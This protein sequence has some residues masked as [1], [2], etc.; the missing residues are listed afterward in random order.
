[1]Q[2]SRDTMN[3]ICAFTTLNFDALEDTTQT[4]IELQLRVM[5]NNLP[6]ITHIEGVKN[7]AGAKYRL[8]QA[9]VET[10]DKLG[11]PIDELSKTERAVDAFLALNLPSK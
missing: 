8:E 5:W 7:L 11:A 2:I 9:I 10:L 4:A 1:M 3:I 6:N